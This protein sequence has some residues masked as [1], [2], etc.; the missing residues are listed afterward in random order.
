MEF[1]DEGITL[2]LDVKSKTSER[3]GAPLPPFPPSWV[4]LSSAPVVMPALLL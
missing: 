2:A 1:I 4:P 3:W